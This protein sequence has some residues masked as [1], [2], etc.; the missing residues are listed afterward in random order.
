MLYSEII[1][2][3]TDNQLLG[4]VEMLLTQKGEY[5]KSEKNLLNALWNLKKEVIFK[6]VSKSV[7]KFET[8]TCSHTF[9]YK[10]SIGESGIIFYDYPLNFS[11]HLF[12]GDVCDDDGD[13]VHYNFYELFLEISKFITKNT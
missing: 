6:A 2:T 4:T 5:T 3:F 1:K 10:I 13:K 11:S 8:V 7:S 9:K 12:T